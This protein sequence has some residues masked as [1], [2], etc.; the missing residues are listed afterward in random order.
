MITEEIREEGRRANANECYAL[1]CDALDE[2][3]KW[4]KE[5]KLARIRTMTE[6][7]KMVMGMVVK[8]GED[9]K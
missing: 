4:E 2:V 9:N 7:I 8:E 3:N 1:L 5:C 6:I